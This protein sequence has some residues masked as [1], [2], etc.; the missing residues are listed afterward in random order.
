M[1]VHSIPS[2]KVLDLHAVTLPER[3]QAKRVFAPDVTLDVAF[4]THK[5]P[6]D[7][8]LH[9]VAPPQSVLER[10]LVT[11]AA[12]LRE[13]LRLEEEAR[14]MRLFQHNPFPEPPRGSTLPPNAGLTRAMAAWQA[15]TEAAS[16]DDDDAARAQAA[17]STSGAR[18]PVLVTDL[19]PERKLGKRKKKLLG[20]GTSQA[21]SSLT[22]GEDSYTAKDVLVL[23]T[24]RSNPPAE[25][26]TTMAATAVASIGPGS[27]TIVFQ[28]KQY[29]EWARRKAAGMGGWKHDT[30]SVKV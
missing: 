20:A 3:I 16:R 11:E 8:K 24:L 12:A 10:E 2:L 5:P 4:G 18:Q 25:L 15:A 21:P 30:L 7:P 13:R 22:A 9:E 27:G 17:A 14:P 29:E 19:I 1:L 6:P 23:H 26:Q 28:Q